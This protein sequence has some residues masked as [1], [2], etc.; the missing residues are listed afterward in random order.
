MPRVRRKGCHCAVERFFRIADRAVSLHNPNPIACVG[1]AKPYPIAI[2]RQPQHYCCASRH[3]R[4]GIHALS[5][6]VC[7]SASSLC[8][9]LT[10]VQYNP[11]HNPLPSPS[12]NSSSAPPSLSGSPRASRPREEGFRDPVRTYMPTSSI[13]LPWFCLK[14]ALGI[15]GST[16]ACPFEVLFAEIGSLVYQPRSKLYD[17]DLA[18]VG[19]EDVVVYAGV[20]CYVCYTAAGESLQGLCT[21]TKTCY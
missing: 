14:S 12:S 21:A 16:V 3:L 19:V 7:L 9:Q 6:Y 13:F 10:R 8:C 5:R 18:L 4:T 11:R 15:L 20:L 17:S 2:S 1:L